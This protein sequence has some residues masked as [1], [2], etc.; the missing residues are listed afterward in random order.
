VRKH[1]TA[2]SLTQRLNEAAAMQT[3]AVARTYLC[4]AFLAIHLAACGGT[5]VSSATLDGSRDTG[6]QPHAC[7]SQGPVTFRMKAPAGDAGYGYIDSF[8][9]PGDQPWWYSV[10]RA[11]GT[12]LQ[13]LLS[14]PTTCEPCNLAD[15]PIGGGC[16]V[17][18]ETG[19]IATW[20]GRAMTGSSTCESATVGVLPCNT[21]ECASAGEY[22]VTM[23][24]YPFDSCFGAPD[25]AGPQCIVVPFHYPTA[26]D[27]V[28]NLPP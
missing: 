16:P 17:L 6:P 12:P 15:V 2:R 22:L 1:P 18:P 5:P 20:D 25:D 28:G 21:T 9:N 10:A 8:G 3:D 19:A 7:T 23:C 4:A 26:S 14:R 13:I 11:D 24:A 27:V